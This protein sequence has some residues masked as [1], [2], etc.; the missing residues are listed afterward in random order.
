MIPQ[1]RQK[2]VMKKNYAR[3]PGPNIRRSAFNRSHG[4]KTCLDA[5]YLIP[6]LVDECLPGDTFKCTVSTVARLQTLIA[7]VMDNL[8]L[9][10]FFFAVP[11]RLL[12]NNWRKFMGEQIDPGDSIDYT[13]P[14]VTTA[15]GGHVEGSLA[16]YYG[17]PINIDDLDPNALH[18]RAYNLIYNEF[19]RD[20]NLQDSLTVNLDDGPDAETDYEIK[21]RGKRHDYFTSALPWPMKDSVDGV[22]LPLG[23]S[24]EVITGA[25]RTFSSAEDPLHLWDAATGNDPGA[26]KDLNIG[27][28]GDVYNST[29]AGGTLDK[30]LSPANLYAD[31]SGATS[32]TITELREAFQLQKM[33]ERDA[34]SGTRYHEIIKSHFGISYEG[35]SYRPEYLGGGRA[36]MAITPVAQTVPALGQYVA[37]L[38]AVGFTA[39]S[40]I[41]FTKSFNEHCVVIGLVCAVADLTYTQGMR[42]MWSRQT[43]Y[44]YYFPSLAHLSEQE[45]LNKEIFAQGTSADDDVF[46]YQER[47]AEYRHFNSICTNL[48]RPDATGA[49]DHWH[50]SQDFASLPVLNSDFIEENPPLS[51]VVQVTDEPEIFMD[52]YF[53]YICAR[54][55]PVFGVPGMIDHF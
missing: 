4:H 33:L 54:P 12:W 11:N 38:G 55:M 14:K 27:A 23:D 34:R 2:S 20:E 28:T 36:K 19:F 21:K 22:D 7:P 39:S 49:I 42:R 18:F 5:G 41:G 50:L 26:T 1:R 10:F 44:D 30:Y 32:S 35:E 13:V 43:R 24:A 48:L 8:Y 15:S 3:I 45:I 46:G 29:T 52:L 6:I 47:F 40:G 16:D 53:D 51:R 9:D 37:D 17:I 31:L 25:D